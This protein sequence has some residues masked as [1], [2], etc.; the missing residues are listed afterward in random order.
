MT[1]TLSA[2]LIL[3]VAVAAALKF[4]SLTAGGFILAALF[5]FYLASTG[6]A[7]AVN[8]FVTAITDAAANIGN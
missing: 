7:P 1:V 4:R 5:G 2:V 6:A 8:Q 3:G